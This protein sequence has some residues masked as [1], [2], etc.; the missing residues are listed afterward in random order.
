MAVKNVVEKAWA[1]APSSDGKRWSAYPEGD[2][3]A[4]GVFSTNFSTD[5]NPIS[6][7]GAWVAPA[8]GSWTTRVRTTGGNAFCD[9]ASSGFNDCVAILQDQTYYKDQVAE[10]TL[11][12]SGGAL[13]SNETELILCAT[14]NSTQIFLYECLFLFASTGVLIVKW[15]GNQGTITVLPFTNGTAGG[16]VGSVLPSDGTVFRCEVTGDASLRTIKIYQDNT[17]I[18]QADDSVAI[19]GDAPYITGAPGIAFDNAGAQQGAVGWKDYSVVTL[20]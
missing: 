14:Y 15:Q 4:G 7:G 1:I 17:L 20:P 8:T 3:P 18:A 13:G 11:Y 19:S 16:Y 10:A 9:P 2:K 6:E 12:L 5:E